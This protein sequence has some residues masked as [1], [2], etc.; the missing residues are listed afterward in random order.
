M[1]RECLRSTGKLHGEVILRAAAWPPPSR[2]LIDDD[3]R[4]G[5]FAQA[6][7]DRRVWMLSVR[8]IPSHAT[9]RVPSPVLIDV[10]QRVA[11]DLKI[12]IPA[13]EEEMYPLALSAA[14]VNHT[15]VSVVMAFDFFQGKNG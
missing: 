9:P 12:V 3:R 2:S 14:G 13:F 15:L 6:G 8:C 5:A 4:I 1:A 7:V 11:R 10:L